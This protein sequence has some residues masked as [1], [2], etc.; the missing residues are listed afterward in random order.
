MTADVLVVGGGPAG[1]TVARKLAEGG[2]RVRLLDAARFPRVKLCAG[3]VTPAALDDAEVDPQRYPHT[4]QPFDAV[5]VDVDDRTHETRWARAASYG[6]VR[7]EF[8]A[9]LLA[10]ARAAGVDVREGQRVRH[11]ASVPGGLALET[12]GERLTAPLVVGAGGYQCPVGRALGAP[13]PDEAVV[14]T[15]ES[16]TRIGADRLRPLTPCFGTP[17][18]FAEPDFHGYGWYFT[19]GDFLNVGVG[20]V[21]GLPIAKRLA[22]FLERLRALGRLP[23][24]VALTPFRGHAYTVRRDRPR[25]IGGSCFVLIGDSAGLAHD[26]SGEGIGPALRSARIAASL[27]HDDRADAYPEHVADAFGVPSR[28]ARAVARHVPMRLVTAA[29]RLACTLPW[30]RRRLVLEGAFGMG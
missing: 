3:W 6:I 2:R 30:T 7:A 8:D 14:V 26:W 19:K 27:I 17:E 18:L 15:Q 23:G 4:I 9:H 21:G 5:T 10:R 16:E 20:A 12:D 25:R 24:G 11:V 29:A 28:L 13:D 1:S 22:R